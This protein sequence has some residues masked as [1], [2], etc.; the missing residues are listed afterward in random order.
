MHLIQML[1]EESNGRNG[2]Q[3]HDLAHVRSEYCLANRLTKRSAKADEL[4]KSV[5]TGILPNVALQG[6]RS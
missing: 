5:M 2:G 3:V 4:S 1:R 6:F